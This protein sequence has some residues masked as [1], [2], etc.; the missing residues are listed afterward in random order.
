MG[1]VTLTLCKTQDGWA[2]EMVQLVKAFAA[3]TDDLWPQG[4]HGRVEGQN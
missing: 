3:E 4:P 2:G 1:R